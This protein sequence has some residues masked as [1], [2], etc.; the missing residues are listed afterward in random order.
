MGNKSLNGADSL[1]HM[2]L[3]G[4]SVSKESRCTRQSMFAAPHRYD[5]V[6]LDRCIYN[7]CICN[8][9]VRIDTSST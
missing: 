2:H 5:R 4:R 7:R 8:S 1:L 6:D 3:Y 9:L